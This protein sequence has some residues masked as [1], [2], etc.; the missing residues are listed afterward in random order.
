VSLMALH[1]P[2]RRAILLPERAGEGGW[3]AHREGAVGRQGVGSRHPV[4]CGA[5]S[6]SLDRWTAKYLQLIHISVRNSTIWDAFAQVDRY[7]KCIIGPIRSSLV[8]LSFPKHLCD[9]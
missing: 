4:A 9:P 3:K 7:F 2:A 6:W 8:L 5:W 1:P